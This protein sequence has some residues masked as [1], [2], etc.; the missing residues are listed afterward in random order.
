MRQ[1]TAYLH[2]VLC[3]ALAILMGAPAFSWA[4]DGRDLKVE[5]MVGEMREGP[6]C[7]P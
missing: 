7:G 1:I 3:L 6:P 4:A 5:E 2:G